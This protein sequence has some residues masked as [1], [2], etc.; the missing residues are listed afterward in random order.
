MVIVLEQNLLV[1][2]TSA[3]YGTTFPECILSFEKH[4]NVNL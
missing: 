3:S 2:L 1:G 4:P